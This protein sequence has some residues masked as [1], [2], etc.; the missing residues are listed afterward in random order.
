VAF[1]LQEDTE[2]AILGRRQGG[3]RCGGGFTDSK[4]AGLNDVRLNEIYTTAPVVLLLLLLLLS[5]LRYS[6]I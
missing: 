1:P 4:N 5:A 2:E 3:G 6:S